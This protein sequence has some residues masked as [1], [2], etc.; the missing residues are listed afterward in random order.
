VT[1]FVLAA[2]V[3]WTS[4]APGGTFYVAKD[5]ND[6]WSG[7]L[8]VPAADRCDGPWASIEKARDAIRALK[9]A[10]GPGSPVTVEVREGIYRLD[11]TLV[12]TAD[13]SGTQACPIT[14]RA[15]PGETAVLTGGKPVAGWKRD[16]GRICVTSLAAQ[17]IGDFR[18]RELF[19]QGRRQILARFPNYDPAH[20]VTGGLLYVAETASAGKNAFHY[21]E[22][23]IPLAEWSDF[24][25]AE[26]NIFPY[27]CW[28]HNILRIARVDP[29]T[30]LVTLRHGVAG[31]IFVGN[32]YFIQN[33]R[34]A[35]DAPAEW[36]SDYATGKL[37]FYPPAGGLPAD[38]DVVVP[39]LENLVEFS[40]SA[41]RPIEHLRFHGFTLKHARQDAITLEGARHCSITGN[42][43]MQVGGIGVNAGYLR[44][45]VKGVGLPWRKPGLT[46][47]H[48]HS[49][50]RAL[51]F[52]HPCRQC[53]I[54]GNDVCSTGGEG[55][56]LGGDGNVADNNHLYRTGI[57]DRVCAG[58]TVCGQRNVAAHNVIH[59]V[60]RDGIF[61]NGRLNLAEYNEIRNSMLYTADNAAIALRQ[62]DVHQAVKN[63]GNVLRFNRLLD[64]VG[65]GSY[66][67]CTHP[68]EGFASPFCSFGI[69]LDASISGVTVYG[70]TI[71]RCGGNSLFIQFGGG[72][73]VE[74]NI[75][76]EGDAARVGF[77]SMVFFGTFMFSDT[78]HRYHEPPNQIKHNIFCYGGEKT[79]LY[80]LGPWDSA[81]QWNQGQA[82]FDENLIWHHGRPIA[83]WLHKT[84]DCGTL[85]QWQARGHDTRSLE[86]DPRFVDAGHDDYRLRP[87]SPA[88][89]VGFQ[90]INAQIEK[91]GAYT[92]DERA[93]WPLESAVLR[94]ERPVVF[95]FPE[96]PAPIID[97]FEFESPGSLPGKL[98]VAAQAPASALVSDE[99]AR[100]GRHS[101]KFT[102][103]PGLKNPWEP[104][105]FCYPNYR[106]GK[107][108]F[109]IDVMN[110]PRS[111]ADFYMEFR[112]WEKDP[113]VGP[114]F[115]VTRAGDFFAGGRMGAG[116]RRMAKVPN[117]Q[118][119]RVGMD[120]QLGD[121]A[122]PRYTLT[123]SVPGQRPFPDADFRKLTWFGISST[124]TDR[125]VFYVD[126]FVLGPAGAEKVKNALASAA[127]RGPK[128][129]A[130]PAAAA[131]RDLRPPVGDWRFDEA[132]VDLVDSSGN[133]LNGD[134]GGALRAQ[135]DFGKALYLDG[136]GGAA[137]LPDSP[138]LEF[139]TGDF[140]IECWLCPTTLAIASA[141]PRRR[142][143]EK[144]SYPATWWNIDLAADGKLTMEMA[145][146]RATGGTTSSAGALR[147]NRWTHLAVTVDRKRFQTRF[148][149]DG[150][151]DAV[152]DLPHAFTG[153]LDV[154]GKPVSTGTWQ[155][156]LGLI[157][158][159]RIYRRLLGDDEIQASYQKRKDRFASAA[160]TVI[161]DE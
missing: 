87:D 14:Y 44:N 86:A 52:S 90:N 39:M 152:R 69:Y 145:D 126:N 47:I 113:L 158:E 7:R 12:F 96:E 141:Y 153:R 132:G 9:R 98:Q 1:A 19:F 41:E 11:A 103:A 101:L 25:Q 37:Y 74:N 114:T 160:Y 148:Y 28:D 104:H 143:I 154:P 116:G 156:Y 36:F 84:L 66:P 46:R 57:Y 22:G 35:L 38:G 26:V 42:T 123:L 125:T 111:P 83:V 55:V 120:F 144:C 67:H 161:P 32:R 43:V 48:V 102:D 73:V 119:Y 112:D 155:P 75:F 88:Y 4:A 15:C 118:W 2:T 137:T 68:A 62:H 80:Q 63:R 16:R 70:N 79:K 60:P 157:G 140:S 106:A 99:A 51:M 65:Y 18:F 64:T 95:D 78:E 8:K 109:A 58:L 27:H 110:D 128:H 146:Q 40:G 3:C 34:G 97:G 93:S 107:I 30:C 150:K 89:R 139:G 134:L 71:A 31:S 77:D 23:S 72:N 61:I 29:E 54:A 85:A 142:V 53:R 135:G 121:R 117:G 50:D 24:S 129:T 147:E 159:L 149:L 6:H 138:L 115:R 124:S 133:G 76:V 56:V 94:R 130:R 10:G 45:A 122:R 108:H 33:V 59:D 92:S 136:S 20:P 81:P 151:P 49:G 5:G 127:I 91:I 100:D 17:G 13:D 82:Q 105:A 21:R 131:L